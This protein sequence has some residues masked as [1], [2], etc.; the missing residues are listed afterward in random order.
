MRKH[1]RIAILAAATCIGLGM[2]AASAATVFDDNATDFTGQ[3]RSVGTLSEDFN[4]AGGSA[5]ISFDLFGARSID[6]NNVYQDV[7]TIALN[8]IDVF[9]GSFNMSGGGTNGVTLNT[10]GWVWNTVTNDGGFFQGGITSVSGI[11]NLLAGQNTFSVTFSQPGP[12]NGAGQ[13]TGDESWALND[14]NVVAAAVPLPAALPLLLAGLAGLGALG[15]RQ[16]KSRS[17]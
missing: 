11:A 13:G 12:A 17:V 7:F 8:G 3:Y 4:F 2:G 14:L 16:R 1:T 5:A 10:L 15:L 6:G 9:S